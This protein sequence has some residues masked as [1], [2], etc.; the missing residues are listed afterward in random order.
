MNF[1]DKCALAMIATSGMLSLV[2]NSI[3]PFIG[4]GV[5]AILVGILAGEWRNAGRARETIQYASSVQAPYVGWEDA[6]DLPTQPL[7]IGNALHQHVE[8]FSEE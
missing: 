8:K 7:D 4:L 3:W 1:A 2:L 5:A 6:P